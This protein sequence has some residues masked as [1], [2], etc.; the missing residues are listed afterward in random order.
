MCA[1]EQQHTPELTRMHTY[2]CVHACMRTFITD[3]AGKIVR[4]RAPRSAAALVRD[5]KEGLSY[6]REGGAEM[7]REERV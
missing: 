1:C 3:T 2:V 5:R 4:E 6:K 7:E